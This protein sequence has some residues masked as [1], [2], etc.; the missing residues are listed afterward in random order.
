MKDCK[1]ILF[2][3]D[4]VLGDTMQDNFLAWKNSMSN[5]EIN[6]NP[7]DY[8][9]LEGMRVIDV[10]KT[11]AK[12]YGK[13]IDY[14]EAV[15]LKNKYYLENHSFRFYIGVEKLIDSLRAA[16]KRLAI[17]SAS[18]KEKLEK[19]VPKEF[20]DKFEVV[21][22]GDDCKIGKPHPE[23][24][25][26]AMNKLGLSI[27]DCV[28]IENAPL[29]IQ[30]AKSAGIYCIALTTTVNREHLNEADKILQNHEELRN[31]LL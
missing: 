13:E 16:G 19:T 23:P 2:D 3:F 27:G 18:P 17:V 30:S 26:N 8:F 10:A 29:G 12:K 21:I 4:G 9:P 25:L 24:Y 1:G 15:K 6:I 22:S 5:F 11:L 31:V 7:E 20:L 14:E 28:V